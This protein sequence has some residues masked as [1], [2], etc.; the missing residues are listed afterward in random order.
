MS[1]N[2]R[3]YGYLF[4]IIPQKAENSW[5]A[6]CPGVGGVYEEGRTE[7]EAI[8]NAYSAACAIL[9]AR[10]QKHD[11]LLEDSADLKILRR[12]PNRVVISESAQSEEEYLATVPC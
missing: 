1:G 10:A 8:E 7:K 2:R 5:I 6:Y 12:L 11:W 9:G 3:I 4:R